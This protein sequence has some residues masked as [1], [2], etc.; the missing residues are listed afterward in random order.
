M[1]I[2]REL[3]DLRGEVKKAKKEGKSIGLVPTMGFLHEGH[4]S[5]VRSASS[6]DD[7]V[8]VS[9]F[10]NPIQFGENEDYEDY[11]RDLESDLQK[12]REAGGDLMFCPRVADMYPPGYATFVE[13]ERLTEGLCGAN[14]PGHFRGV[15]TVVNK[16]FNL[17][18]PDRAYF[19]Q[20][21][22]Q[23]A[24]TIKRMAEDL[25]MN[26]EVRVGPVIREE[27]GVAL[28]S[29]NS[30][31]SPEERRAARVLYRALS[32]ARDLVYIDKEY[33]VETV[34]QCIEDEVGGEPLAQLEY[35]EIVNGDDLSS[36]SE[37]KG[38]VLIALAV[39]IGSTRL[40]DNMLL[41]V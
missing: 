17:V 12:A 3:D 4:L 1:Q 16:L 23:Q 8:V 35:A 39:K 30:Y 21:D 9:V 41:E 6:Q 29:R 25:N 18:E 5:L 38:N 40:I 20:K 27:D 33:R 13:V 11:P 2:V 36:I 37:V 28:S 19:G 22:A 7:V 10:V 34:R 14:R 32:K 31:L 24:L 15:T 26:V